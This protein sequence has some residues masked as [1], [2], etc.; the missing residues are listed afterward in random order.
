MIIIWVRST[1]THS[2]HAVPLMGK[3]REKEKLKCIVNM[4]SS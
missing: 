4:S 2:L 1:E 3:K